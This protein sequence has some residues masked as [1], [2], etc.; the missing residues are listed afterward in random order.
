MSGKGGWETLDV[1]ALIG[2]ELPEDAG[3][4]GVTTSA[5]VGAYAVPLGPVLRRKMPT[6]SSDDDWM[7]DVPDAYKELLGLN[8]KR[9]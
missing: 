7:K 8:K 5:N 1:A 6:G 2:K 3:M 4:S 9:K